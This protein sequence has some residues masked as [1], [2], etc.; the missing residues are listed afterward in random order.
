MAAQIGDKILYNGHN[1]LLLL[2][3]YH[4]IC[5]LTKLKN[6]FQ[7]LVQL[8]TGG[9]CATWEI[10]NKNIYLLNVKLPFSLK[11]RSSDKTEISSLSLLKPKKVIV[12][13][14]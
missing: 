3:R 10:E 8:A 1:Y 13:D 2:K 14:N 12:P 9:Y 6:C 5:T 7:K 4:H 11:R